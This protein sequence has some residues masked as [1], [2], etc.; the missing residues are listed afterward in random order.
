MRLRGAWPD[1]Q[2]RHDQSHETRQGE[3]QDREIIRRHGKESTRRDPRRLTRRRRLS[4]HSDTFGFLIERFYAVN[5]LHRT[6]A[7]AFVREP[8]GGR[9]FAALEITEAMLRLLILHALIQV[10]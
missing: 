1:D 7:V 8:A 3:T 4:R 10:E 6:R 2:I 9:P 5:I